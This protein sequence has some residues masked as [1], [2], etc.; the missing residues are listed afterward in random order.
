MDTEKT[1]TLADLEAADFGPSPL[2]VLGYPVK[3]SVSPAMHNAALSE[4]AVRDSR[5]NDWRYYRFEVKPEDLAT[6][7][8]MFHQK[9]FRGLNLTVPHKVL[10]LD[11]IQSVSQDA[12][13]MGAVNTLAWTEH[14][15]S[16]F[17][18]D[19]YG[20][21][22]GLA[23]DL[24]ASMQDTHLILLGSG[25]A[26][27]AAAV[28]CLSEGCEQ[29]YVGN[30]SLDRL[31]GLLETLTAMPGG[32]SVQT[33]PLNRLP[34][35]L[36]ESGVVVNATALGLK[37]EDSAPIDVLQLPSGWKVYDMIYNPQ[38]TR[39]LREANARGLKTANGLSML[40]H[41]G[42]RSLE[43]WSNESVDSHSMQSAA[44]NALHLTTHHD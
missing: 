42:A 6:A 34:A 11:L 24:G 14:G 19:G 25:G 8:P 40:V 9:G 21:K 29:L 28:Q 2:A 36:P 43:I 20:L 5:F 33:F 17:N 12:E 16:G 10:A 41:Q 22:T 39:L 32:D 23:L 27:R 37:P 18:T 26:A 1:Y 35:N 7:L 13:R 3:H 15:Y 44:A 38:E 30:R 31:G 4:L